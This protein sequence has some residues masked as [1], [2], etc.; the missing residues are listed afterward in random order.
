MTGV[1][2]FRPGDV[3]AR[4][5][6]PTRFKTRS[7]N[8]CWLRPPRRAPAPPLPPECAR[9]RCRQPAVD[10]GHCAPHAAEER[11]W[12]AMPAAPSRTVRLGRATPVQPRLHGVTNDRR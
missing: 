1:R 12:R 10:D 4:G 9:T 2:A 8:S 6:D 7:Y 11:E 5:V 3:E